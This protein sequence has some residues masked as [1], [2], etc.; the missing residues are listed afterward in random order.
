MKIAHVTVKTAN[1]EKEI[2]FYETYAQMTVQKDMRSL[3]KPIVFLAQNAGD[4]ELEIIETTEAIDAG[5]ANLSI[6]FHAENLDA[7]RQRLI[8]DG[9]QP[10]EMI[11]PMPQVRFFFVK[12]PAGVHVQFM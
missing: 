4:T 9:F 8:S 2:H 10:T 1:F 11:S 7:L 6:G 12:D 3:G 5:N